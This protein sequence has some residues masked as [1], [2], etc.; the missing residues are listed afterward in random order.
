L[1]KELSINILSLGETRIEKEK[2]LDELNR[3]K[4][5]YLNLEK[6]YDII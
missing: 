2:F 1:Q 3:K 6:E 5:S 4:I